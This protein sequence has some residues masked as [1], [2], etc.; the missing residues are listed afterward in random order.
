MINEFDSC[1]NLDEYWL[2]KDALRSLDYDLYFSLGKRYY[3]AAG[4]KV[5]YI[6][7]NF[8]QT[9]HMH[10]HDDNIEKYEEEWFKFFDYFGVIRTNDDLYYLKHQHPKQYEWY[11]KHA[12]M[13]E[14]CITDNAIFRLLRL[15]ELKLKSVSD[16]SISTVFLESVGVEK[17]LSAC[18]ELYNRYGVHKIKY[19]DCGNPEIF[20]EVVKWVN[21]NNLYN[22]LHHDFR[23]QHRELLD[24]DW[25]DGQ[26]VWVTHDSG[27]LVQ[28]YRESV[29]LYYDRFYFSSDD[30]SDITKSEFYSFSDTIN[31]NEFLYGLVN[32]KSKVYKSFQN[33]PVEKIFTDYY[34]AT[35]TFTVNKDF[36]FIPRFMF[37]STAK[38]FY[39]MEELGWQQ[40][41]YGLYLNDGNELKPL[42]ERAKL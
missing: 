31:I 27:K 20:K 21:E 41:K 7:E 37:P 18:K 6:A 14:L 23:T 9:K 22:C 8:E 33:L 40:T 13:F 17:V 25:V 28:V 36:N 1:K 30:A 19:I 10:L 38:F 24:Y 12:H 11:L 26:T 42:I 34:K 3:C 29:H 15:P 32:G 4:C 5:C 16:I 2:T 35:Q 39:K